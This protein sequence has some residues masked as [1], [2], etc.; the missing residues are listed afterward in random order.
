M[1]VQTKEH[2]IC[3]LLFEN[4]PKPPNFLMCKSF[5]VFDN[6]YRINLY[7]KRYVD[8]IE[9]KCI[10]GSYFAIFDEKNQKLNV[11]P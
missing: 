2:D 5:N 8:G 10:S 6:R 4:I 11:L 9:G 7:S 1:K 3:K